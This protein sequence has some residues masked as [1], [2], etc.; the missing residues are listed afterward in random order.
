MDIGVALGL[1]VSAVIGGLI[2]FNSGA[3][4][5]EGSYRRGA[6][7]YLDVSTP[8]E[9]LMPGSYGYNPRER[10]KR[11]AIRLYEGVAVALAVAAITLAATGNLGLAILFAVYAVLMGAMAWDGIRRNRRAASAAEED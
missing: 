4:A 1:I 8:R 2:L 6:G 3:A 9:T 7:W 10:V 5:R 11:W